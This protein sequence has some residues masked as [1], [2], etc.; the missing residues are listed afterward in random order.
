VSFRGRSSVPCSN[1]WMRKRGKNYF[2]DKNHISIDAEHKLICRFETTPANV[3]DSRVF[4]HLIDPDNL[5]TLGCGPIAPTAV[6]RRRKSYKTPAM[7]V[8]SC[9]KG[10]RNQPLS[11]EQRANNCR[12]S[13]IRSRVEHV[14]GFQENSMGRKFIRTIGLAWAKVKI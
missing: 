8:T 4:D 10:Q 12:R 9:E 7:K 5:E 14:F 11:D 1:R 3:H 13:K 6:R 2:G